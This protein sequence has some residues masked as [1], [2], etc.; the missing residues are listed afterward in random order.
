MKNSV[1]PIV[2]LLLITVLACFSGCSD[3]DDNLKKINPSSEAVEVITK[4]SE[5]Y[6]SI[7]KVT[8]ADN[9]TPLDEIVCIDFVYP[10]QLLIYNANLEIIGSQIIIDDFQFSS[11]LGSLPDNQ[12]LSI[13]YPITTTLENGDTFSVN[14]NSEL[15]LAID[16]CSREDIIAFCNN[17]FCN[18]SGNTITQCFWKVMYTENEDNQYVSGTFFVAPDGSLTFN[19]NQINYTGTWTFL[20]VNDELH[21]N[22]NLEGNSSVAQD[23]N[24]DRRIELIADR[25]VIHNT[26]KNRVIKQICEAGTFI[27]GETG[28]GN[29]VVFYDKG[30]YSEGWRYIEAA[31][32][33][34]GISEWGCSNTTISGAQ[35]SGIGKGLFATAAI[36][37]FHDNRNNYYLN[38]AICNSA[39]NGTVAAKKAIGF[40]SGSDGWFLPSAE[41]LEL[42]YSNLHLSGLGNFSA[43]AYW[44]ATE[45]DN[46]NAFVVDFSTGSRIS[47]PKIP[48]A[49]NTIKT[50]AVRYF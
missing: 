21:L 27:V 12:S 40:V 20:F 25:M 29:G 14:N 2:K 13:S 42:M 8:A 7:V 5:L 23:W 35:N 46:S 38:P 15:K 28:P 30:F 24:I 22:I 33:D 48:L 43:T 16:N 18:A 47:A 11:F 36:V 32:A 9:S 10:L 26:P 44:S 37:N 41:E 3:L 34:L 49:G 4:H 39:N 45:V 6:K 50:R 17:L 31:A 19:Y 1:K